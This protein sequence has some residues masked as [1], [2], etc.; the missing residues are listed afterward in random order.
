MAQSH[1]TV[2]QFRHQAETCWVAAFS[3][4]HTRSAAKR[5]RTLMQADSLLED[6]TS[7]DIEVRD[8][9]PDD[10]S[11]L[12]ALF[13]EMQRHYGRPVSSAAALDAAILAC[14]PRS[15]TFD[16]HV[17]LAWSGEAAVGSLVL[18]VTFPAFE[19]SRS[20]YIRDLYVAASHR[21]SGIGRA[22]VRAAAKLALRMGYSAVEWTTDS[23]NSAA[24]TMYESC[25][26][27]SL[28]RTYYRLFDE[29]LINAAQ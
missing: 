15:A 12:A 28:G 3:G 8:A 14:R 10:A 7:F 27:R 2:I 4:A 25:G 26:A 17:M 5:E 1:R 23:G 6:P 16:P 11:G 21:R 22:F 13:S 20:L 29:T 9:I 19:L 18:N 24:R